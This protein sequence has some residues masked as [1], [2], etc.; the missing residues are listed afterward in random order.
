MSVFVPGH[1]TGFFDIE[2]HESKLKNGSCG[3]GFLINSGV[4]TTISESDNFSYEVNQGNGIIIEEVLNIFN[5]DDIDFKIVQDIQLPVGAG[6]GTSAASA[7]SLALALNEFLNLNY[8][9]E[10]CG[11]IAHMA[12]V[13]LGGGLGDV[14]AQTGHGL[15]LRT[16]PGAPGIGEIESFNEDVYVAFKTFGSIETSQIITNP[17]HKKIISDVGLKYLELFKKDPC[18]DNFL[19]FSNKFSHETGLVSDEVKNQI[20]YF[21]S[22]DDILG[23][24]MAMLGNTVFAFAYDEKVFENL[25]IDGLHIDKLNNKGIFYD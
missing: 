25:N 8:S 4:R 13:N 18:L 24:S 21:N 3:V 11:Q 20:E 12:E 22:I 7:L 10:L 17:E 15:V 9:K 6:F 2:N 23:S 14:I 19:T 5:L 16:M 1:I